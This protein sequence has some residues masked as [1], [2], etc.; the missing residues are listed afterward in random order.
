[1]GGF[2]NYWIFDADSHQICNREKSAVI[3]AFVRI[4]PVR[5]FVVLFR[6]Q[7]LQAANAG[8]VVGNA[9]EFAQVVF[10]KIRNFRAALGQIPQTVSCCFKSQAPVSSAF[11]RA[12]VE[13]CYLCEGSKNARVLVISGG[14]ST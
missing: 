8:R 10:D 6:E 1:M 14:I 5:E 11:A 12:T 13:I 3:D 2:E 7:A 9:V 4:L